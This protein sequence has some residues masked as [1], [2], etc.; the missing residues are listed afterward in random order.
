MAYYSMTTLRD[1]LATA[2]AASGCG[3]FVR[4][5]AFTGKEV[6]SLLKRGS[7]AL[8]PNREHTDRLRTLVA[9]DRA[10]VV[11]ALK[12]N[13]VIGYAVASPHP[14]K[15]QP[16]KFT[17]GPVA[18]NSVVDARNMLKA[19]LD[20]LYEDYPNAHTAAIGMENI[21]SWH[22]FDEPLLE[23]DGW[24]QVCED[25]YWFLQQGTSVI[26]SSPKHHENAYRLMQQGSSV[27]TA[28]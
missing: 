24:S 11:V 21:N 13:A 14:A 23:F 27:I 4:E 8:A 26:Q 25:E 9:A 17:I 22:V 2:T 6:D 20:L 16:Q 5:L 10:R 19:V 15:D 7:E 18:A 3:S 28:P 1:A 12:N